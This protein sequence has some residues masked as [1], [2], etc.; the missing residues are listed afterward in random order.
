M[1]KTIRFKYVQ[2]CLNVVAKLTLQL[3]FESPGFRRILNY[4]YIYFDTL[5]MHFTTKTV[6]KIQD[7]LLS[8][9]KHNEIR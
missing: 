8:L 6:L 9:S 2:I 4:N 3:L 7:T 1:I 5:N